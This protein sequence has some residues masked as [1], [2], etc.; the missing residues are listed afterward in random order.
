M[1]DTANV[2]GRRY[3]V[4]QSYILIICLGVGRSTP[5]AQIFPTQ[6][7]SALWGEISEAT[8]FPALSIPGNI[9]LTLAKGKVTNSIFGQNAAEYLQY[10]NT[11]N[12]AADML[13]IVKAH[14]Q[15]KLNYYGVSCVELPIRMSR[16][17]C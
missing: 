2:S 9:G 5:E 16:V 11:P 15:E 8:V 14:G 6:L 13:Q 1:I 10:I 4:V 17:T 7:A 3:D 12:T